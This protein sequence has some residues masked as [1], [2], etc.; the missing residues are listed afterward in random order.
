M[1]STYNDDDSTYILSQ[2]THIVL[3]DILIDDDNDVQYLQYTIMYNHSNYI[4]LYR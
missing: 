1:Y 3:I 2:Y 4:Q